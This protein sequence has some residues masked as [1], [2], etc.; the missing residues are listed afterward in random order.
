MTVQ[1]TV[2]RTVHR[3]LHGL[4]QTPWR[5]V[6]AAATWHVSSQQRA[7]HNALVASTALTERRRELRDVEEFLARLAV[8]EPA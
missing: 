5:F 2:H 3:T 6:S 8:D 7:R 1:L 4:P